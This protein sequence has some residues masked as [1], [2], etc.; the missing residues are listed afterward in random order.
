M[1]RGELWL[2]HAD[3]PRPA[4]VLTRDPVADRLNEVLVVLVTRTVRGLHSEVHLERSDGVRV[5]CVANLDMTERLHRAMFVHRLGRVWPST[6]DAIC[7]AL[8]HAIGC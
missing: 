8:H 5:S 3:K 7:S 2:V 6:M 4:I 1:K